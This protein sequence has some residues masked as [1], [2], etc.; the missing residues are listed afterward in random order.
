MAEPYPW[1]HRGKRLARPIVYPGAVSVGTLQTERLAGCSVV[2]LHADHDL[3]TADSL[4][5]VLDSVREDGRPIVIDLSQA[6][7]VDSAVLG[8]LVSEHDQ[9]K[10]SGMPFSIVLGD[11]PSRSV[12][13]LFEL[14]RLDTVLNIVST[15]EQAFSAG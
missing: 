6:T 1:R 11:P 4:R 13:R 2:S 12:Q 10:A 5:S 7:F 14:T 8:V 9:S 3:S 15:R